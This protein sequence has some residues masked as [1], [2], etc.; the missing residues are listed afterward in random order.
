MPGDPFASITPAQHAADD[1]KPSRY[2][3]ASN[4]PYGSPTNV[5]EDIPDNLKGKNN[6]NINPRDF[7]GK[8]RPVLIDLQKLPPGTKIVSEAELLADLNRYAELVPSEKARIARLMTTIKNVEGEML[9]EGGV[10]KDAVKK[11]SNIH[12]AYI[13]TA[14]ELQT[15]RF[16]GQ[17][18]EEQLN[19]ELKLLTK[20]YNR[21]KIVG[22]VGRVITVVGV[23]FTAVDVAR[24][25]QRSYD[26]RSYK[27]LAAEAVRQVGGWSGALAGAEVGFLAGA[28]LGIESGPGLFVTGAIGSIIFGAAGY[29]GADWIADWI[30][31]DSVAELRKDVNRVEDLRYRTATLTVE[32]G[33]S[34]YD[35]RRRALT[36]AAFE[37]QRQSLMTVD[38]RLPFR[39]AEKLAP[40]RSSNITKDF[41]MNWVKDARG[42]N[43]VADKN[44]DGVINSKEWQAEQETNFTYH[45][46]DGEMDELIRMIL[47]CRDKTRRRMNLKNRFLRALAERNLI[48]W[49]RDY[50]TT[51]EKE[52]TDWI[53]S[54]KTKLAAGEDIEP[55][56]IQ[57]RSD[58]PWH[59]KWRQG[60]SDH[61][62][63]LVWMPFWLD[64][65]ED[66]RQKYLQKYP[67][68]DEEWHE[69]LTQKW[70]SKLNV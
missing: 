4:R 56:W 14:E 51:V 50:Y 34:Q 42:K 48:E 3:S 60:K 29:F 13:L 16:L 47:G 20:S 40:L 36:A 31:D 26:K 6:P 54:E 62:M 2:L 41:Q 22:R 30:D 12:S 46:N 11:V 53:E 70:R 33:E 9:I 7:V 68:P 59:P 19:R 58:P 23:V 57:L 66:R 37:A 35:F 67:P 25:A 21:V 18:T 38:S 61:W 69:Y 45:L 39:Y 64:L 63:N 52:F 28:A 1:I 27:P 65:S 5:I 44:K 10:P 55:P 43:P 17:I 15:K 24:A 8:Q 32:A 49:E